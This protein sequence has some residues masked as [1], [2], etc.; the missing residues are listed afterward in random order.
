M[1]RRVIHPK[2]QYFDCTSLDNLMALVR[3]SPRL[4]TVRAYMRL[5]D[6]LEDYEEMDEE[7]ET[8]DE[9]DEE[10]DDEIEEDG[11]IG[12]EDGEEVGDVKK[13]KKKMVAGPTNAQLFLSRLVKVSGDGSDS[14]GLNIDSRLHSFQLWLHHNRS[15]A[16][17][18]TIG[19]DLIDAGPSEQRTQIADEELA[20]VEDELKK[21]K[22]TLTVR[23][24]SGKRVFEAGGK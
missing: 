4:R 2:L 18:V 13:K 14:N 16:L 12:L 1:T 8:S 15:V 22:R 23:Q 3:D 21:I 19:G 11:Q 20:G 6:E 7:E 24:Q 5:D 17:V 10:T 9:D